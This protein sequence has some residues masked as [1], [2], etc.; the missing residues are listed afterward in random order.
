[1]PDYQLEERK[2]ALIQAMTEEYARGAMDMPG[3]EAA[4]ARVNACADLPALAAEASAL[5][6]PADGSLARSEPR[7]LREAGPPGGQAIELACVSGS[8]RKAGDWVRS[9]VYKLALKS[10]NARLDLMEYELSRGFRLLV[11]VEAV[12]SNLLLIVPRGFE[13]EERFTER[14]SSVVRNKPRVPSEGDNL[15]VLVGALKSSTVR[16]KYR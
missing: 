4:V 2:D 16:V 12:S 7:E 9:R 8:V 3:F 15:V 13:V 1:M 10:S 5:G 6:L 11:A 14:V